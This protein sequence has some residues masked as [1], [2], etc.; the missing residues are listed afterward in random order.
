MNNC[1]AFENKCQIESKYYSIR[2]YIVV[3]L[4]TEYIYVY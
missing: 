2:E 3:Y 4:I 1:R